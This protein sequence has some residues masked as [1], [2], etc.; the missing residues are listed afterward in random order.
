MFAF[1]TALWLLLTFILNKTP[2]GDTGMTMQPLLFTYW[3]PRHTH[4][5]FTPFPTQ[6]GCLGYLHQLLSAQ[7]LPREAEDFHRGGK[8]SKHMPLLTYLAWLQTLINNSRLISKIKIKTKN[9]LLVVKT[10]YFRN[11]FPKIHSKIAP[12]K[13]TYQNCYEKDIF[14]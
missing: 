9:T 10:L 2:S 14:Y 4:F 5:W 7:P 11:A 12:S 3:L 1:S 8:H 6:L 13:N